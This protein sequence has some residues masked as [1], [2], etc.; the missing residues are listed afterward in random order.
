MNLQSEI[1]EVRSRVADPARVDPNDS[2]ILDIEVMDW[3]WRGE[4]QL[5]HDI[6]EREKVAKILTIAA[7]AA[8]ELYSITVDLLDIIRVTYAGTECTRYPVEEL[9][10]LTTNRF[11]VP[12]KG[13]QQYFYILSDTAAGVVPGRTRIGIQPIPDDTSNIIIY[14]IPMPTRRFKANQGTTTGAGSSTTMVDSLL[15]QPDDYW[16]GTQIR[17]LSGYLKGNA[18][19]VTDF[20]NA[21]AIILTAACQLLLVLTP[22][23]RLVKSPRYLKSIFLYQLLGPPIKRYSRTAAQ[24]RLVLRRLSTTR[25]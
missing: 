18:Q 25:F 9:G 3:L 24:R 13:Q 2:Y 17:L 14:Y 19:V 6:S 8:Q 23:T 4:T 11:R 22:S 15:I 16:N 7:V 12:V 20:T 10:A 21:G 1:R 5:L